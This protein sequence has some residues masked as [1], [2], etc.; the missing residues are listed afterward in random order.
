LGKGDGTQ[1]DQGSTAKR[2]P[3]RNMPEQTSGRVNVVVRGSRGK[4]VTTT[5][6]ALVGCD[7]DFVLEA[8]V[9]DAIVVCVSRRLDAP[10]ADYAV[11]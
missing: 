3:V 11:D 4:E 1:E 7:V 5:M 8:F 9:E 10:G 2:P 6:D